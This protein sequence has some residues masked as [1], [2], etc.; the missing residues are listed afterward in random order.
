MVALLTSTSSDMLACFDESMVDERLP[1]TTVSGYLF[2]K[3]NYLAF[4]AAMRAMLR[5]YRLCY[6]RM[7]ECLAESGQFKKYRTTPQVEE[8]EREVIRLIRRH[9]VLGVGASVSESLF[10]LLQ[11]RHSEVLMGGPYTMLCQWCLAEMGKWAKENK[12]QREI[13]YFFEAGCEHQSEA[14]ARLNRISLEPKLKRQYRYASH[15]I[16]DKMRMRGLQAADM[17]AWFLRRESEDRG[18][19]LAGRP[20]RERRKDFQALIGRTESEVKQI[21]HKS[22]HFDADTLKIHFRENSDWSM[23]W[24]N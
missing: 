13:A 11:P 18:A 9:A 4:D 19:S 20:K 21:V 2:E 7:S 23:R 12:L 17:L 1:L 3:Q 10:N 6:F 14:N 24:W 5:K 16:V 22:R 8:V 15:S